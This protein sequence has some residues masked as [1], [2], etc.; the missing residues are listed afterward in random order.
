MIPLWQFLILASVAVVSGALNWYLFRELD[1]ANEAT[2]EERAGRWA[3]MGRV[4][5]LE[6]R[7]EPFKAYEDQVS[8]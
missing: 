5:E 3:A 8:R 4:V 2:Y 7:L 6:A 1:K